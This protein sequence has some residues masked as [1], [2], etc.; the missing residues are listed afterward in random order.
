MSELTID[1]Q[2]VVDAFGH[3]FP[4]GWRV[5]CEGSACL[6]LWATADSLY[7]VDIDHPALGE[8]DYYMRDCVFSFMSSGLAFGRHRC[9]IGET[10]TSKELSAIGAELETG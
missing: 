6:I 1:A 8:L 3:V 10:M 2:L 5:R 9:R 7:V 4:A